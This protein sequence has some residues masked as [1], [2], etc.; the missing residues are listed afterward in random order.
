MD[1][2]GAICAET[3]NVFGRFG[4]KV[5]VEAGIYF[6]AGRIVAKTVVGEDVIFVLD[7]GKHQVVL[8]F[9]GMAH[10]AVSQ[11]DV[12]AIDEVAV[13]LGGQAVVFGI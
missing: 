9:L 6:E 1:G 3:G 8:I 13:H 7:A 11:D 12:F 4:C 10:V 2:L 5:I